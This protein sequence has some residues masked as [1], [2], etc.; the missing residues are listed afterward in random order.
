MGMIQTYSFNKYI[1]MKKK[2]GE[3]CEEKRAEDMPKILNIIHKSSLG[4]TAKKRR[5]SIVRHEFESWFCY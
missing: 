3:K 2:L 4:N 1:L 5:I